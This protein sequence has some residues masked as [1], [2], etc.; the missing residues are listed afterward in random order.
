MESVKIISI[1]SSVCKKLQISYT[2]PN[3]SKI[4]EFQ[5]D[6][7]KLAELYI[8]LKEISSDLLDIAE[9]YPMIKDLADMLKRNVQTLDLID[10]DLVIE[11]KKLADRREKIE[12]ENKK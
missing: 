8:K 3:H 9:K 4:I 6:I 1:I 12:K 10:H 11:A 2:S 7:E 5:Q